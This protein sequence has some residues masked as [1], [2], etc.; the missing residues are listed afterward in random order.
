MAGGKTEAGAIE[1]YRR[2]APSAF[3]R[4]KIEYGP[5]N[6]RQREFVQHKLHE[7]ERDHCSVAEGKS[8]EGCCISTPATPRP[9]ELRVCSVMR[10]H[11]A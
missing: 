2:E 10:D 6:L 11:V 4:I 5:K 1:R 8:W 7:Q 9:G 3:K